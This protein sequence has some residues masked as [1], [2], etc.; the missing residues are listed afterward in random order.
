[1]VVQYY[2]KNIQLSIFIIYYNVYFRESEKLCEIIKKD[3]S[4]KIANYNTPIGYN[5]DKKMHK[6]TYKNDISGESEYDLSIYIYLILLLLNS[7]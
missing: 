1:M 3:I 5:P 4:S 6:I 2:I 7:Y